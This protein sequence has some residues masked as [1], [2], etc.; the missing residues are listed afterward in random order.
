MSMTRAEAAVLARQAKTLKTPPL[1]DRF[2]SKVDRR[3]D[4]ECWPWIAAKRDSKRGYGAFWYQGRHRQATYMA[5]ILSGATVPDGLMVRHECDN[6]SCCNPKHL[7]VGTHADNMA[8]KT[9]RG[10]Q[11]RGERSAK[12]K[13]TREQVDF[14]RAQKPDGVKQLKRGAAAEIAKRFGIS[15]QYVSEVFKRGWGMSR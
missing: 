10:R 14:I 6:P 3:G 13:L 9:A 12:A 7:L 5:L 1:Q 8:D 4:D 11:V 15:K 2:W